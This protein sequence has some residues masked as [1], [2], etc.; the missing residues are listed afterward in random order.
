MTNPKNT[1]TFMLILNCIKR[2]ILPFHFLTE[3]FSNLL[4][5]SK[6]FFGNF[7]SFFFVAWRGAFQ[8]PSDMFL[9]FLILWKNLGL[10]P[11]AWHTLLQLIK[12]S[13]WHD[14]RESSRNLGPSNIFSVFII[15]FVERVTSG[16]P[17]VTIC[18]INFLYG[19][20]V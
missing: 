10:S 2:K 17:R 14:Q 9:S 8:I 4:E 20:Y 6:P 15:F 11:L 1:E 5:K 12:K 16:N 13:I 7:W 18:I 19:T 3:S